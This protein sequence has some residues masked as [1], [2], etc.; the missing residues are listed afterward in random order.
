M[1]LAAVTAAGAPSV[2]FSHGIAGKRFFPATLATDD[3]FVADE[4]SLPLV[5]QR[6]LAP[7]G[8]S[9]G[10]LQTS[11]SADFTKRI[12]PQ[13]GIGLGV[14]YLRL[15]SDDGSVQKG[16]DNVSASLKYQFYKSDE[17][18]AIASVGLDW[19]IGGTGAKRIGAESFSTFTPGVF[20]GKGLGDLPDELKF[21]RPFAITGVAGL[22]IPSRAHSTTIDQD[23][24]VSVD[25]H[26]D[27]F[28]L[29]FAVEYSIP[30]LQSFVKDMGLREPFNKMIPVV[31]LSLQKP[32]D[33]G[34]SGFTGTVNPGIVWAGRYV[35]L[36]LEAVL[37]V[38]S[39][40]GGGKGV[41]FQLHF[42]LDDIFPRSIGRP[43]F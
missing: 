31:E 22:G 23:G 19:D 35:Q 25:Q 43:I 10:T 8:D 41:L 37:P 34:A 28:K 14:N 26:P 6:K 42:F 1:S 32:V 13:L 24:N 15:R 17:H 4:L 20:L 29:G 33:R 30:Y 40:T 16:F 39:R 18:E 12:T 5:S 7:S 11:T 9:P 2:A 3:P 27:V 36:G 38:N 21:L